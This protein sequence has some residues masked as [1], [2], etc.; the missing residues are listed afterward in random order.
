M[1][2]ITN[3]EPQIEQVGNAAEQMIQRG[4]FLAP[5]IREMVVEFN[6]ETF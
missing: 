4:H 1:V 5:D 2:E 6:N 3:H